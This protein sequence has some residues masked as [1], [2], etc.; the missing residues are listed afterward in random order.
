MLPRYERTNI[1]SQYL[2][3]LGF[4]IWHV[5]GRAEVQSG[6]LNPTEPLSLFHHA[7][8]SKGSFSVNS[9]F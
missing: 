1:T 8:I 3:R 9:F 2:P 4:E 6:F 7:T 5:A